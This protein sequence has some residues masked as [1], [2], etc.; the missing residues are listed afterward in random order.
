MNF[1]SAYFHIQEDETIQFDIP[2]RFKRTIREL[3]GLKFGQIIVQRLFYRGPGALTKASRGK[4]F[5]GLHSRGGTRFLDV[6]V[7]R[8]V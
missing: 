5:F 6:E 4:I 3:I 1:L 8:L 7:A 2:A